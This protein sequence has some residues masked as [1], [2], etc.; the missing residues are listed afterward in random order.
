M[1]KKTTKT[2]D[3]FIR[4]VASRAGFTIK[5]TQEM[6]EMCEQVFKEQIMSESEEDLVIDGLFKLWT[7][8]IPSHLGPPKGRKPSTGKYEQVMI[9]ES[10]KIHFTASRSLLDLLRK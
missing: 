3:W 7:Q 5:D 9:P 6:W 2:R 1:R 8:K 4:E 10:H